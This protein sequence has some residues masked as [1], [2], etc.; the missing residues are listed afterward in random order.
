MWQ[1]GYGCGFGLGYGVSN[2]WPWIIGA[3]LIGLAVIIGVFFLIIKLI[4]RG[5]FGKGDRALDVLKERFV[6]G[7]IGEEEYQRRKK[8][9]SS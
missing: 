1:Y 6:L 4:N 8:V 3:N 2:S 5:S 9:L 7:E